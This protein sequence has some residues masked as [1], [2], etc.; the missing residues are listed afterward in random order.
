V[1]PMHGFFGVTSAM[2]RIVHIDGRQ[3]HRAI[4]PLILRSECSLKGPADIAGSWWSANRNTICAEM[5][6]LFSQRPVGP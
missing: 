3:S 1:M 5:V 6:R 2:H 4:A